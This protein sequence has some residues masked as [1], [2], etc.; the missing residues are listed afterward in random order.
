MIDKRGQGIHFGNTSSAD[1]ENED[2]VSWVAMNKT[3]F[4][5][6]TGAGWCL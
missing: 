2:I 6:M 5:L 1:T 4:N 3:P